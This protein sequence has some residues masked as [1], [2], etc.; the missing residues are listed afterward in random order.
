MPRPY[1]D[2]DPIDSDYDDARAEYRTRRTPRGCGG[3]AAYDG[4]CGALDCP[5]CY[6]GSWDS[7]DDEE[8]E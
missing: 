1:Y 6:P 7:H 5:S 8:E 4:P 2:D 3:W